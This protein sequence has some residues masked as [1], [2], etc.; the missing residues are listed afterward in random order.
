MICHV[1]VYSK[2]SAIIIVLF[3]SG[4][5]VD[6]GKLGLG[7][8]LPACWESSL[9]S[10]LSLMRIKPTPGRISTAPGIAVFCTGPNSVFG[11]GLI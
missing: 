10:E 6:D 11:A 7:E 9:A 3:L 8:L 2:R 4:G 5:K 1:H